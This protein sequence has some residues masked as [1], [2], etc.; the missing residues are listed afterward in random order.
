MPKKDGYVLIWARKDKV[1][2]LVNEPIDKDINLMPW[3]CKVAECTLL[4]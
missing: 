4:K 1:N 3:T 2:D